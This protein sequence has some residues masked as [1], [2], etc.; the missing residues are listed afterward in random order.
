MSNIKALSSK[1]NITNI[2]HM[3]RNLASEIE[4]CDGRP[5]TTLFIIGLF[6]NDTPPDIYQFGA[7]VG[8]LVE[9]GAIM[10]LVTRI[11]AVELSNEP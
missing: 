8:R 10:S 9:V 2:P 1:N 7:E 3:L 5:M 11:S 4:R 6:D